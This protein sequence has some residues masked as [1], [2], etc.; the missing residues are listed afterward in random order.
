MVLLLALAAGFKLWM[1]LDALERRAAPT[2]FCV[3]LCFPFGELVYFAVVKAGDFRGPTRPSFLRRNPVATETI[4]HRYEENPC[5]ENEVWLAGRLY[6][7]AQYAEALPLY[8]RALARDGGYL[9][10]Q[11]GYGLCQLALDQPGTA[12]DAF[13]RLLDQDRSYA[14]HRVWLDLAEAL[15]RD[16]R[17]GKAIETLEGLVRT[18]P[19]LEHSVALGELLLA[20]GRLDDARQSLERAVADCAHAPSHIQRSAR[21]ALRRAHQILDALRDRTC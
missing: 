12:A 20:E 13:G 15:E 21:P 5:L 8:E 9:R 6:D 4:R 10:A 3:I 1:L 7:E 16:G 14:D 17:T 18:S 19:R 11:Y 2:W